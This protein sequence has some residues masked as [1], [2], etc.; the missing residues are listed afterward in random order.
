MNRSYARLSFHNYDLQ[1]LK[2]ILVFLGF[3]V[4]AFVWVAWMRV[5]SQPVFQVMLFSTGWFTW[6][7]IEYIIHRFW[8]HK[9]QGNPMSGI[10]QTHHYH[11]THPTE[12]RIAPRLQ[13]FMGLLA[14]VFCFIAAY[15]HNYFTYLTGICFGAFGY[16]FMHKILHTKWAG[17]IFKR[18]FRYH[19]YHHC[20]FPNTCFGISTTIWDD[21]YGT[22]P[23]KKAVISPRILA[24]YLNKHEL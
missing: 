24:F 6:T 20:K 16:I 22:M 23:P 4:P 18:L 10:A 13:V 2:C 15:L 17:R 12:I 3:L 8:M 11:H 5:Y 7:F 9:K 21:L 14:T 1:Q 19:I